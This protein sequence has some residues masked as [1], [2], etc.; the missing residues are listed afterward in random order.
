MD[1]LGQKENPFLVESPL[2]LDNF[3]VEVVV[4]PF[5]ALFAQAPGHKLGNERPSLRAV[6]FDKA[7][8]KLVFFLGP[9]LFPQ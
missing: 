6:L 4:P 5:P 7:S 1:S 3:R 9:G 8:H 2:D